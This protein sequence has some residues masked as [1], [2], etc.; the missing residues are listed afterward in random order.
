MRSKATQKI[1]ALILLTSFCLVGCWDLEEITSLAP[2]AAIGIDLGSEPGHIRVSVQLT[3]AAKGQSSTGSPASNRLRVITAEGESLVSAFAMMQSRTRRRHFFLHLGYIVFGA[4]LARSGLGAVTAGMQGWPQIRGSTLVF[5]AQD[6]AEAVLHAHS[7][8]G[9]NPGDDISDII[10]NVSTTPVARKMTLND[11]VNALTPAG[12]TTLTLPILGLTPLALSSADETPA[13]GV[14]QEGEQFME[15]Y[16]SGTALFDRDRW[17]AELDVRE[18]Q[19]LVALL[20]EAKQGVSTMPNPVNPQG[21]IAP[22]YEKI[23]PSHKVQQTN[24]QLQVHT[25]IKVEVRLTEIQ[26]GY[27]PQTQGTDPIKAAVE[28]DIRRRVEDLFAKLQDLGL[29]SVNIGSR[30]HKQNPKL[31]REIESDWLNIYPTVEFLV[32]ARATVRTLGLFKSFAI[33]GQ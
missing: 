25:L 11:M 12:S 9:G 18:T 13:T 6:T 24:G 23:H 16:L 21:K 28:A 8:I 17:V 22:R 7:G 1:V 3:L 5:V 32:E 14:G 33:L 19:T 27:D 29:D 20:G 31:W 26:G 15:I 30:I 10:R 2:V 4:D